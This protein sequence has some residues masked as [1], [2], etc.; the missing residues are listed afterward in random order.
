MQAMARL[1]LLPAGLG[2]GTWV[3]MQALPSHHN[4]L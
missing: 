4:L 3:A 1:H 2:I